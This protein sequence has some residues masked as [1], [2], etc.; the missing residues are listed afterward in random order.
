[1]PESVEVPTPRSEARSGF[2]AAHPHDKAGAVRA[3]RAKLLRPVWSPAVVMAGVL[4][5][6]GLK[7]TSTGRGSGAG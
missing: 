2:D 3:W 4:G 5:K 1:M 6:Y 7:G